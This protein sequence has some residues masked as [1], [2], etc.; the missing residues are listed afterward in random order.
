MAVSAD[1]DSLLSGDLGLWLHDQVAVRAAAKDKAH[2]RWTMSA[3]FI[4]PFLGFLWF[5]PAWGVE[6]KM[7]L[8]GL[9]IAAA[10]YW[11]YRPIAEA[12]KTVKI[13]INAAIAQSLGLTYSH[14][15]EPGHEWDLAHS[16]GLLPSHD[17]K[18]FEDEWSGT[19]GGHDFRLYEAHLE[20]QR[21]SGKNR[22]W[23]TVYRGAIIRIASRRQFHGVT[24][25]QRAGKHKSFFG[26]G[27]KKDTVKL[28]GLHLQYVDMVSPQFEDTFDLYSTD[29]VEARW[30]AHPEYI[31]R[32]VALEQ[33]FDGKN[34]RTL[35]HRGELVIAIE[36]GN[37]FESGSIN[38]AD[39]HAKVRECNA[40]FGTL[41][42]LAEELDRE[43]AER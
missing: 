18:N 41:A 19:L 12:K 9:P 32:L 42:S 2:W 15:L 25:L 10:G 7:W 17:R 3:V 34:V 4:L 21:G 8:T 27:G 6:P 24:L 40:Q 29:Q 36:S 11:G 5:G 22:R 33:S 37:M 1:V 38:P 13:G 28:G 26:L 39:D 23:V 43:R 14:E 31:E 30:L 16:F 35:F 20:E